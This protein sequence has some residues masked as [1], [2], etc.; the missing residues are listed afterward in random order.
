MQFQSPVERGTERKS[1]SYTDAQSFGVASSGS[2][3]NNLRLFSMGKDDL[4]DGAEVYE[5]TSG[6]D[7][8]NG[9]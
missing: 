1:R 4:G 9:K 7:K 2:K 5:I 3:I 6:T 8:T